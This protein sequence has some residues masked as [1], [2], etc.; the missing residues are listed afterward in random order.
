MLASLSLKILW[1]GS[2]QNADMNVLVRT[3][4]SS[5]ASLAAGACETSC[6]SETAGACCSSQTAGPCE[7]C[8]SSSTAGPTQ[9]RVACRTRQST[10]S[11]DASNEDAKQQTELASSQCM[12]DDIIFLQIVTWACCQTLDVVSANPVHDCGWC[13]KDTPVRPV[14]PLSPDAPV[15]PV[16]PANQ[17][18]C[19]LNLLGS[20]S[21]HAP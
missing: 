10:G 3:C 5:G 6:S 19:A 7:A 15:L 17:D 13:H 2:L 1:G 12:G 16:W 4:L 11:P 20:S 9:P 18:G 21:T 14:P 8:C